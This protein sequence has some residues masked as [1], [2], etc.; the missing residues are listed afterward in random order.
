MSTTRGRVIPINQTVVDQTDFFEAD[1]YTRVVGLTPADV[2]LTMFFDNIQQPW[3]ILSGLGVSD[4]QVVSGQV[5]FNE[6]A[7]SPGY[8]SVRFRPN[9]AGYWRVIVEYP[10]GI[11]ILAQD[12]DVTAPAA[13]TSSGGIKASFVKPCP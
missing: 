4:A 13:A 3:P 10:V 7:G 5:Y 11:Q 8:Y 9:A 2:V 6:I 1:G 12:Y